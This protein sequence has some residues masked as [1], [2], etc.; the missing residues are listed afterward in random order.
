MMNIGWLCM[1]FLCPVPVFPCTINFGTINFG[2][3]P[4]QSAA[5]GT[6]ATACL[7]VAAQGYLHSAVAPPTSSATTDVW[8]GR[9]WMP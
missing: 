1:S 7:P 6:L 4:M 9:Q 5:A 8:L 3:H 2:M